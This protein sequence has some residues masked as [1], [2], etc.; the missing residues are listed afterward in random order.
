MAQYGHNWYG[1]SYYG[2]T[3]AF[4]GWYQTREIFTDE[5]LKSTVTVRMRATLPSATY[6]P[7]SP[8]VQQIAGTWVY[9]GTLGKI[10]SNSTDAELYMAATCDDITIQYE[11]RTIG[12]KVNIEVTTTEPGKTP[13]VTTY[14]LN[15]QSTTVDANAIYKISGIPFGQQ[16][17]RITMAT[18][19]PAGAN[20]NFKG[21]VARTAHLTVE[22]RARTVY[23][24][25]Q[26]MPDSDYAK[27]TT[28]VTP[29]SGDD[30]LVEAVTPS[31]AGNKYIQFKVYL[32]SS[33]NETSPE[34]KH[35]EIIAGDTNNRTADGT[36]SA[37]FNMQ[38]IATLAGVSFSKVEEV[39]WTENVPKTTSLTIRSQSSN[40]GTY[41]DWRIEKKTVPYKKGTRRL[42]L[43]EGFNTGWIDTPFIAPASK[44]PYVSTVEWMNWKDQSFLPPDNS[45]VHVVYDFISVQKDNTSRP[46]VRITDPMRKADKNLAG[47][48]RLRNLD[49]VIRI[50]LS[51]TTGKQ[52]PVVDWIN[53]ESKMYY[54]QDVATEAQEFSSVDF[55]NTGKGIM[56]DMD[57]SSFR[58][59]FK[60]PPETSNPMYELID[61]TGRPQD[62]LL[63][64]DSE[65]NTAIRT[66]RTATLSNKVWAEAKVRETKSQVGLPKY[67]QYGGGQVKF[68]LKDEIQMAPI[69]TGV[70]EMNPR[71]RYRYHLQ[72]GWPQQYHTV[73]EGDTLE[74][75]AT[76][77]GNTVQE[78]KAIN[79][80]ITY[81]NNG[82]LMEGQSLK[83]PNDSVNT[84]VKIYWKSTNNERTSK[85]SQNS[86]IEGKTNV[87][88]DSIVAEVYEASIYGWV[89]WVSE[90]KIYDGVVNPNDIRREYKRTHTAPDS[91]DSAQLEYTAVSGDTY[92][93]VA[94][95]FG[96]YEEDVR[97]LN[98]VTEPDAQPVVG[99][100]VLVP[101]RIV[102]P[103][104]LPQAIVSENPYH[105]EIVYNS[106]KKKDGKTLTTN[107]MVVEPIQI[108]Y[109]EVEREANI[110]RGDIENGKDLLPSPRVTRIDSIQSLD[111]MVKYNEWDTD[112]GIGN[113]VQ[114]GN[115]VD[116]SPSEV[117]PTAGDTY[118]V[119]YYCEV[120]DKVTVTIDT[121]YQEEGGVDRIWRSPEVKEFKGMC[122]PGKDYVAE[123]PHFNQWMGLPDNNIEDIQYIVEDNDIWVK[124]WIEQRGAKWYV[125]GSLQDRVPKDN[126][127][128]TLKTGYYYLGKDEYYMFNEPIVIEPTERDIPIAKNVEF[129]EGKFSNAA[130]IQEGSANLVVNSGFDVATADKKTV[131]KLTF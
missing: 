10:S 14:V 57:L 56:L 32:A 9:D 72:M 58:N 38:E 67:Y 8:E 34:V 65:S 73:T 52:T 37:V 24:P 85:S 104:I 76:I 123:L 89:D 49:H 27:L 20:F 86:V 84:D 125:V 78:F 111:G 66:N 80:K 129:V 17:V 29:I 92:K 122:Y 16:Q 127:F 23:N 113:F 105:I 54:Q 94:E 33:D 12:A 130:K 36:W 59:K 102:L 70:V 69:F 40:R 18:D 93:R 6:S 112:L 74:D 13:T 91:G 77:H 101:S 47:N 46:Y 124:T 75:I 48:P 106:V 21:F 44:R 64:L 28:T 117:E 35:I 97:H 41:D 114:D 68:P 45:G 60:V 2:Q 61:D 107:A 39:D 115:W 71:L 62:V 30:Y 90:E 131:F 25:N 118:T 63:Y 11:Q 126:W 7:N 50:T 79:P 128:P 1:T 22:S 82:T 96:V 121:V 31:Y 120:P 53:L 5:A 15:T 83:I 19:S 81:N 98:G 103:T 88:S 99:Q 55:G 119:R 108:T 43:K 51:R 116:W 95:I 3:N 26:P 110:V 42:R 87:E 4:S 109:K 100:T